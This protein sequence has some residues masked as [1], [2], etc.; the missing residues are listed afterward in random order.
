MTSMVSFWNMGNKVAVLDGFTISGASGH[1]VYCQNGS[2][3]IRHCIVENNTHN[4]IFCTGTGSP[5][6]LQCKI[7]GNS[8]SGVVYSMSS[9]PVIRQSIISDQENYG[10]ACLLLGGSAGIYNNTIV[11]NHVCGIFVQGGTVPDI[12][13]CI[14]WSNVDDLYGCSADSSCIQNPADRTGTGNIGDNPCFVDSVNGDYHIHPH[15][16]CVDSGNSAVVNAGEMDIDNENRQMNVD[17]S[18]QNAIV[19]MG[20]DETWGWIK[21]VTQNH[22]SPVI[23]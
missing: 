10:I 1:G 23:S 4:G 17:M 20:A 13:N 22:Y 16:P 21:N 8:N 6:I 14:L 18:V 19:D 15:S 2:P 7:R 5:N 11:G 9:A 12:D 3:V